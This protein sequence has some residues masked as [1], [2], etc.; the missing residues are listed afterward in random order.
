MAD[1]AYTGES[2]ETRP[3]SIDEQ[4]RRDRVT[5]ALLRGAA[6]AAL[7]MGSALSPPGTTVTTLCR[8]VFRPV[9]WEG[10][11]LAR[12]GSPSCRTGFAT[13]SLTRASG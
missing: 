6:G 4:A 8:P 3:E 11:R 10:A 12:L 9:S 13:A 7:A 2:P 5:A 1:A